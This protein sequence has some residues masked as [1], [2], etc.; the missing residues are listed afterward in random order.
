MYTVSVY[1]FSKDY[2]NISKSN[3]NDHI[4]SVDVLVTLYLLYH[5][6]HKKLPF[7][8]EKFKSTKIL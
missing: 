6:T 5:T 2:F 1:W 8:I 7:N 4:A 3:Q